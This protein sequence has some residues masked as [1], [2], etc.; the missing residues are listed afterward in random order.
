MSQWIAI[1]ERLPEERNGF[2]TSATVLIVDIFGDMISAWYQYDCE[3]IK[4]KEDEPGYTVGWH[5]SFSECD[6]KSLTG[7]T[8]WMPAIERP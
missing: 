7:I 2:G 5:G 8:H 3:H 4:D 1:E 6:D